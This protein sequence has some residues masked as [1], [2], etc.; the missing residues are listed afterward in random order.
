MKEILIV[1]DEQP[2][3]LALELLL[4]DAG[5]SV[6]SAF[7]GESALVALSD[8]KPALILM[9]IMM[10]GLSGLETLKLIKSHPDM[11][12]IPVILMSGANI[13]ANQADYGWAQMLK[14]PF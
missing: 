8:W 3:V 1:D 11:S 13:L 2:M 7:S 14:K 6:R 4:A 12:G 5:Y 10:A 9:D